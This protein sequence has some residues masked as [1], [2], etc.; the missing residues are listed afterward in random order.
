MRAKITF[1]FFD[2]SG[3]ATFFCVIYYKIWL[4]FFFLNEISCSLMFFNLMVA[5]WRWDC[6]MQ[7]WSRLPSNPAWRCLSRLL[8]KII[9]HLFFNSHWPLTPSST[10][11]LLVA[12]PR[13]NKKFFFLSLH[14]SKMIER[15][16]Y[17][18]IKENRHSSPPQNQLSSSLRNH[19]FIV[20]IATISAAKIFT[21]ATT[22]S[23]FNDS[24]EPPFIA[25]SGSL[26]T[27]TTDY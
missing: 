6:I 14:L 11:S 26:F 24:T 25:N 22:E 20:K 17:M 21:I 2:T 23:P 10:A 12:D 15:A 27:G 8:Q 13:L 7:I 19:H 1:H 16:A 9:I 4:K 5:T 3:R 18:T